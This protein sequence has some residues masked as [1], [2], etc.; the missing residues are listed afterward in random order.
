MKGNVVKLDDGTAL[1]Y[2]PWKVKL[3]LSDEPY[4]K[5]AGARMKKYEICLLYTSLRHDLSLMIQP[6]SI[7]GL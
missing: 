4:E 5:T 1:V 6:P 2:E 7:N 3:D